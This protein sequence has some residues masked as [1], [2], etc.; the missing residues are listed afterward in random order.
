MSKGQGKKKVSTSTVTCEA[1]VDGNLGH[2]VL[3]VLDHGTPVIYR[4]FWCAR[5]YRNAKG[6]FVAKGFRRNADEIM[7]ILEHPEEELE[8][9]RRNC[10]GETYTKLSVGCS[11]KNPGVILKAM[12][13]DRDAL[14][15]EYD[16]SPE[17]IKKDGAR[18]VRH[19]SFVDWLFET[20]TDAQ[21]Q[22]R[23]DRKRK[24]RK[25]K[26]E[27]KKAQREARKAEKAAEKAE[28]AAKKASEKAEKKGKESTESEAVSID[29]GSSD[30]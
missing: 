8:L 12:K 11:K 13:A 6:K 15:E 26:K 22:K 24:E 5:K 19:R 7:E 23:I 27:A 17:D 14:I 9:S 29:Q 3:F 21:R 2:L 16:V 28:K 10:D 4:Q 30:E 1:F 20:E 25:A 18:R